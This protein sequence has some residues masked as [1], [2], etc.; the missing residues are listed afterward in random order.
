[1]PSPGRKD[2]LAVN[3]AF[4]RRLAFTAAPALRVVTHPP[5]S[6]DQM[7][8]LCRGYD[9]GLALEQPEVAN[10]AI[11][12]SNKPLTYILAGLPVAITAVAGNRELARDLGEG[13]LVYAPGDVGALAAGL[14][15]WAADRTLLAAAAAAAWDAARR[16]WHWEHPA[17]RGA[18]LAAV[19]GVVG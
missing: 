8:E 7:V 4:L 16:R 17:E 19:A 13:A 14:A 12:L 2:Q 10:R 1:M 9:V 11:A 15:R 3:A 6:P 5:A 18:L